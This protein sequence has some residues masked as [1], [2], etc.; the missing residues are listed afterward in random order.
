MHAQLHKAPKHL[1]GQGSK[2]SFPPFQLCS[3]SVMTQSLAIHSLDRPSTKNQ[4]AVGLW[5]KILISRHVRFNE[6]VFPQLEQH[7]NNLYPLSLS[8]EAFDEPL[9]KPKLSPTADLPPD[10]QELVDE[11]QVPISHDSTL[12][13]ALV[14]ETQLAD[15]PLLPYLSGEPLH[16]LTCIKV[17]GPRHPTL[18]SG[19]INPNNILPYPRGAGALL[20]TLE[21]TPSTCNKA[22]PCPSKEVWLEAINKELSSMQKMKVW[23]VVKVDPTYKLVGKTWVFKTKRNHLNQVV[24]HKA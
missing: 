7:S 24:E 20:K 21:D 8:W 18:L 15:D 22:I 5:L 4:E 10:T 14:D 12:E 11:P 17:I 13:P 2:H 6:A 19:N 16:P 23:D 3:Y 9:S 1:L